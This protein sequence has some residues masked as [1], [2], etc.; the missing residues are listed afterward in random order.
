M[1]D[2]VKNSMK[3]LRKLQH[4]SGLFSAAPS[5]ST[6]Y[7]RAWIRDTIY[8]ALA[9]EQQDLEAALNAYH[10]L[11]DVLLKHEFKIDWAINK[12]PDAAYKY[13]HAR[14]DPHSLEEIWEEWGNKQNDAIGALLFTIGKL[15]CTGV[16]VLRNV[17]DYRIL[18]KLVFYLGRVEYWQDADNGIW[19]E[20]EELHASSIGACVAGLRAV[21]DLVYVPMDYIQKG[22]KALEDLLPRESPGKDVDLALL[23]L[24]YP[25]DVVSE[26]MANEILSNVEQKLGRSKGVIRYV[27][28]AYYNDG[29]EAQWT[30]GFPWLAIIYRKLGR[31]DKHQEYLKKTLNVL[32]EKYELPELYLAESG[33]GNVNTPL[34]WSQGMFLLALQGR[35]FY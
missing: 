23:S 3:I 13:I 10:G 18:Q 30:F 17:N 11:L 20:T 22:E 21:K 34:G 19:E 5:T 33:L 24:I 1:V 6:G 27:G 15:Q 9:L 29:G 2:H 12:K 32:N 16:N 14:Y 7:S 26:E 4:P 35:S 8:Q 28:D 31:M 25:Y